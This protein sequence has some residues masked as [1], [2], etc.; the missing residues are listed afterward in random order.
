MSKS[1]F[2][3]TNGLRIYDEKIK[4]I[5]KQNAYFVGTQEEYNTAY[6]DGLISEGMLIVITDDNEIETEQRVERKIDK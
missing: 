1:N 4:K 6:S 2:L 3:D 5:I